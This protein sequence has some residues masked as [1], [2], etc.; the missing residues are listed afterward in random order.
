[1]GGVWGGRL[2]GCPRHQGGRSQSGLPRPDLRGAGPPTPP[3]A[4]PPTWGRE[5]EDRKRHSLVGPAGLDPL[6][7]LAHLPD[8]GSQ[9]EMGE[10]PILGGPGSFQPRGTPEALAPPIQVSL[11]V[12]SQ[13]AALQSCAGGGWRG[14]GREEPGGPGAPSV[15]RLPLLCAAWAGRAMPSPKG[16]TEAPPGRVSPSTPLPATALPACA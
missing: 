8:P 14:R 16:E 5:G 2:W 7:G 9:G 11:P 12:S 4:R 10:G 1:M 15:A 6:G 3:T 13:L